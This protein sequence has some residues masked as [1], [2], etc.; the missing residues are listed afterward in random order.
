MTEP[1]GRPDA[2]RQGRG[3]PCPRCGAE[4]AADNTPLCGCAERASDA[5]RDTRTAEVA[6]A[7]DFDPLRIRPY[8][9]IG[10]I[11]EPGGPPAGPGEET[12]RLRQ[13]GPPPAGGTAP[14]PRGPLPPGSLA[15]GPFPTGP[16]PTGSL[17]TGSLPTP[18]APSAAAPDAMDLS[19]FDQVQAEPPG[20]AVREPSAGRR[21]RSLALAAGGA[22]MTVVAAAGFASGL[23]SYE[24]PTRDGAAAE[25]VRAAVPESAAGTSS[26]SP[27][28]GATAS[29]SAS[30]HSS[31]SASPSGSGTASP[32][33]SASAAGGSP[34]PSDGATASGAAGAERA[35]GPAAP[36]SPTGSPSATAGPSPSDGGPGTTHQ[37]SGSTT[38]VLRR[39]DK[40]GEV[41]ELQ[42]RLRQLSL[43]N[44]DINGSYN[45]QVENAVRMYQ[46]WRGVRGDAPGEYGPSTRARLEAETRKP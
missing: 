5:L 29:P 28:G 19:L 13:V 2:R 18:L 10:E 44:S 31:P 43:Y 26:A 24:K 22:A 1:K 41:A 32:S 12:M 40:G 39:G 14:P 21:R 38:T 23:F 9:E 7:E 8:V 33:A 34:S 46:W 11:V 17:P 25:D 20:G 16:F 15:T 27:S 36:V 45:E 4:R 6:A 42:G 35:T 30:G 3:D 37:G